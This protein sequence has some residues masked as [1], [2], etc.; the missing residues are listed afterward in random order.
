MTG[1]TIELTGSESRETQTDV[2]GIFEFPNLTGGG[3]YNVRPVHSGYI[4]GEES[5]TFIDLTGENTVAFVGSQAI[6]SISGK[7]RNVDG[8][9]AVG[10]NVNLDG[11]SLL[12]T[13]TDTNGDYLFEDLGSGQSYTV[14]PSG[15]G[16]FS[17]LLSTVAQLS[18][19]ATGVD[20]VH[21]ANAPEFVTV[22]G[23]VMDADGFAI[24]M[25][26]VMMIG[27]GGEA[28]SALSNPFG[29]FI[30]NEVRPGDVYSI[31]VKKKGSEFSTSP[32]S[33]YVTSAM[34]N[35]DFVADP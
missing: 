23:R 13:Q 29:Y 8:S 34:S 24:P 4:F 31:G 11:A 14:T 12:T 18:G 1:V 27:P 19:H 22:T 9:P 20:F 33:I 10:V 15:T 28:M 17:P 35:V 30:F 32:Y 16:F 5:H 26:R 2:F 3:N 25:A 6:F 21:Y 7:I